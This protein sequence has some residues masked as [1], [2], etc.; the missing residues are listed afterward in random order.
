[1]LSDA[2]HRDTSF[3]AARDPSD[4]RERIGW[5]C[6]A[7]RIA[8][9]VWIGWG[10]ATLLIAWRDKA[11]V[12][13]GWGRLFAVDLSGISNAR[14]VAAFAVALV[15]IAFAAVVV[16]CLW[17]LA[18]TYLAGRVFTVDAALWLRRTGIAGFAAILVDILARVVIASILTGKIV[19][20]SPRGFYYVMP[21]DVLH[22]IFAAFVFALAY[23]FRAAAEMADD[24][25]QI[26]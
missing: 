23:I 22:L 9:V 2:V 17:R 3:A 12:T 7:L 20:I 24:H 4:L 8:A 10:F 16:V 5:I 15:D 26:V 1:M 18:A 6:H 25:A 11:Q 14:Y 13:E 19:P 21:Q